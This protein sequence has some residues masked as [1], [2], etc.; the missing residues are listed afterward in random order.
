MKKLFF[1]LLLLS[2]LMAF[3]QPSHY[4]TF[5][6]VDQYMS[7]PHHPDFNIDSNESFSLTA[8]VRNVSYTE[9]P[10]YICKR[11]AASNIVVLNE[12]VTSSLG[13]RQPDSRSD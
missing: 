3:G 6:G 10:R 9:Y 11:D 5:N 1:V 13:L 4:L 12:A 7:I 2:G 8:W